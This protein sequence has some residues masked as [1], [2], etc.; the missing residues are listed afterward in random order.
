[1]SELQLYKNVVQVVKYLNPNLKVTLLD[2]FI[3][4]I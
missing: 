1:M 3:E 2:N 4:T